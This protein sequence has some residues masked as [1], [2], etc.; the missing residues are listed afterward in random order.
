[1][2][3]VTASST[4]TVVLT[5]Y[6]T[7]E[8]AAS[9][10]ASKVQPDNAKTLSATAIHFKKF[11]TN[12]SSTVVGIQ[13]TKK[14]PRRAGFLYWRSKRDSNPRYGI[15][16]YRI[17]SPAHSTTLPP[18]LFDG[19]AWCEALD[20]SAS[21]PAPQSGPWPPRLTPSKPPPRPCTAAAPPAPSPNRRR[22]GS[23]PAPPPGSGPRPGRSRSGCAP[24]RSCPPPS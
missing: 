9:A 12:T 18:L 19:F 24:A 8:P 20:S 7:A 5:P 14:K 2:S 13:E 15:T 21:R 16:V 6:T 3:G 10:M 4:F 11:I 17:S 22:S 1:M 23:S